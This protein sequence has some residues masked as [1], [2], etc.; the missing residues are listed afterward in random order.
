MTLLDTDVFIDITR[1]EDEAVED[2]V[3][4]I[5]TGLY[6]GT[7]TTQA[8]EGFST[9][10][11]G[12]TIGAVIGEE[13]IYNLHDLI[14]FLLKKYAIIIKFV[15]DVPNKTLTCNINHLDPSSV[16]VIKA[17]VADVN[18]CV[19][20][21]RTIQADYNKATYYN[22]EDL[23]ETVT[24][25]L[26]TDGTIDTDGT[27]DRFY[28]VNQTQLIVAPVTGAEPKTFL[29]VAYEDAL[30][31][32]AG[33]EFENEINVTVKADSNLIHIGD[34]GQ[35]Y[36]VISYNGTVYTS[37]LTGFTE[38]NEKYVTLK[39]GYVRTDLTS[40]LKMQRRAQR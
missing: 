29:E 24:Y 11:N 28:P 38:V 2:I 40:I 1:L 21:V 15:L 5:L 17:S 14:I 8:I 12:Q 18:E 7:D 10:V 34:L 32:L 36:Q 30:S 37:I 13:Y 31:T 25:Y 27:S 16:D 39:L 22:E 35:Y 4:E 23:T 6:A 19:I 33:T 9:V 26:H 20:D 3:A